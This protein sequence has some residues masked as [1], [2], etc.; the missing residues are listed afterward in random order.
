AP[1]KPERSARRAREG[2]LDARHARRTPLRTLRRR[3]ARRVAGLHQ[4]RLPLGNGEIPRPLLN[5][6][7]QLASAKRVLDTKGTKEEISISFLC[8]LRVLCVAYTLLTSSPP[9]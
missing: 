6:L 4:T 2:R 8:V 9:H 5:H 3:Q 1:G 7:Q